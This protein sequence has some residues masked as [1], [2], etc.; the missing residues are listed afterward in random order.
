MTLTGPV[1][2]AEAG[3]IEPVLRDLLAPVLAPSIEIDAVALFVE[4]EPGAPFTVHST[5]PLRA[6][7]IRKTVSHA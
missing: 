2:D 5:Y 6:N 7:E 4:P 3:R 1:T